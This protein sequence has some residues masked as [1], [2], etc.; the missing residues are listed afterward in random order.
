[1]R[2][3]VRGWIEE[4]GWYI[5][6]EDNGDGMEEAVLQN[7]LAKLEEI[8]K[9]IHIQKSSIEME[10]GQMGLA[11]LYARMYLLYVDGLIFR[12]EN[13]QESGVIITIGVKEGS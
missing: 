6:V 11:N 1:M 2:I 13:K 3:K 7:L 12:L 8:R 10:I 5:S 9:K 4:N